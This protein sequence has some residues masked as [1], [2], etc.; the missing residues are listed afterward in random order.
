M[1]TLTQILGC[2]IVAV[3]C[4]LSV[5]G[6]LILLGFGEHAPIA[7]AVSASVSSIMAYLSYEETPEQA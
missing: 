3:V 2:V 7:A 4:S 5:A 6:V 1:P